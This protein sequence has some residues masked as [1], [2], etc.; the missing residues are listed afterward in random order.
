LRHLVA[1]EFPGQGLDALGDH[2]LVLA[3]GKDLIL[4]VPL[5]GRVQRRRDDR[6]FIGKSGRGDCRARGGVLPLRVR[7]RLLERLRCALTAMC[8]RPGSNGSTARASG[9]PYFR[10]CR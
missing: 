2:R 6:R 8:C 7:E 5:C 4:D 1:A 10:R 3:E 9:L